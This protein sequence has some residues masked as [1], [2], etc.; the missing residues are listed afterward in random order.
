MYFSGLGTAV[1]HELVTRRYKSLSCVG[2]CDGRYSV[3]DVIEVVHLGVAC[4]FN[5]LAM[6]HSVFLWQWKHMEVAAIRS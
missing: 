4:R 5:N 1:N 3:K 6:H 2:F